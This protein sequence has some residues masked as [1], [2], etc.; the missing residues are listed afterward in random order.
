MAVVL[1]IMNR[2][3]KRLAAAAAKTTVVVFG[4]LGLAF[5]SV[6]PLWAQESAAR[7]DSLALQPVTAYL[8]YRELNYSVINWGLPLVTGSSP[9]KKEPVLSRSKVIR[10]T[11]QLGSS[12]SDE[13]GFAWDRAAGKL[14]LDLNRN[15]DLTDDP[16]GVFSCGSLLNDSFQFFANVRL[17]FKTPAGNRPMLADLNFNHYGRPG[18]SVAMR[19]FWQGK[20]A[21]Q[22]EEWEVGL[23]ANPLDQRASFESGSLLLRPWSD[24]NKPFSLYGGALDAIPF[25]RSLFVGNQAYQLRCTNE[26]QGDVVRVQMQFTGQQPKLGE[27][28]ITGDYVQRM[29]LEGGPYLVVLDKPA[30]L[31]KVPVG[32]Y[33]QTKV[34]LKKGEMQAY[35]D[36]Q[37]QAAAGHIT[38]S[39]TAPAILTVGGP[40]TNSVSISREG[41]KLALNYRL[42]GAGG[43]YQMVSQD[44]SH[45][46]EFAVY[47]GDKKVGSGKFEF[48]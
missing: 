6:A 1:L 16:A 24:R 8:D 13:M 38:V 12:K 33:S 45:P 44:R 43:A 20:V 37:T 35:L 18:C 23:L 48:G 31:V 34:C 15:L 11:L 2:Q 41:R 30:A 42:V 28:K 10:G 22:G 40:L 47:Q 19:S 36:G 3:I 26:A 32:R 25:S 17:P 29:T 4:L 14:Y 27:L 5:A 7:T 46:P 21:L 39:E 9:F